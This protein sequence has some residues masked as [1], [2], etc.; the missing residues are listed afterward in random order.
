MRKIQS[1]DG[2]SE[3]I[4][5]MLLL[6]IAV[7]VVTVIYM[8]LSTAQGP[9]DITNVT[10]IGKM[11]H[12]S[13]VFELQRGESLT[14]DT[15][16]IITVAGYDQRIY[17]VNQSSLRGVSNHD[18]KSENRLFY[19]RKTSQDY[20]WKRPSLI[21]KPTLLS[22]GNPPGWFGSPRTRKRWY[23]AFR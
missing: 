22:S 15:K 12:G 9:E 20:G 23:M 4:G 10:I 5:E 13:P 8:Q 6:A 19:Q 7:S 1:I 11:E 14:P 2:V 16:I 18:W 17:S 3:A 21:K